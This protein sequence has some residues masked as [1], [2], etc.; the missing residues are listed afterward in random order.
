MADSGTITIDADRYLEILDRLQTLEGELRKLGHKGFNASGKT[1]SPNSSRREKKDESE[2]MVL[3]IDISGIEWKRSNKTGG[4]AAGP[5]DG[6]AWA[7]AYTQD[8][9]I[10]R[11]AAQLVTALEQYGKVLIDGFKITLAGRDGKLL[12]RKKVKNR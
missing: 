3:D 12:N 8:G 5:N 9:G 2:A 11:E 6:W 10:Q 4:G 7:F 1:R